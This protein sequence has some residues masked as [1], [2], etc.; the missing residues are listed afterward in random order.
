MFVSYVEYQK[1]IRAL[2][3]FL[4]KFMVKFQQFLKFHLFLFNN[5]YVSYTNVFF[6][7]PRE[8]VIFKKRLGIRLKVLKMSL[9]Y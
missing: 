8:R 7:S 2:C 9:F 5:T 4:Y 6:V 3:V 1:Q